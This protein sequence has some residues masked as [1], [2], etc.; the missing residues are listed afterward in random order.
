MSIEIR[1]VK[2]SRFDM[3]YLKFG[4]GENA[5]VMIPGL[6]VQSV[7][8]LGDLVADAYK[9]VAEKYTIYMFDRV[10][11]LPE[12]YNVYDMA[13]DTAEAIK[14]LGLHDITLFGASQGGMISMLI[15]SEYPELVKNLILGSTS[16]C[17]ED[18]RYDV[19]GKWVDLAKSGDAEALYLAFGEALY[20]DEVYE[21]SKE[22]LIGAAKTVTKE[23][24]ERFVI[25]ASCMNG[26]NILDKLVKI[27]CSVLLIGS[28]DDKVLG[29]EATNRIADKL[30][31]CPRLVTHMY[32]GYGHAAYDM[33]PD[34]KE[35]I[36]DFLK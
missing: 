30:T 23:D 9:S 11:E 12:A 10:K 6:S 3:D 13:E 20:T 27:T 25:L 33:A 24:L 17:V 26:F 16:A 19:V 36:L 14:E 5:F 1:T 4:E 8:G 29:G 31:S 28:S 35:R 34:Y 18:A 2:T 21:Q 22:L 7:M 32:D 15:A